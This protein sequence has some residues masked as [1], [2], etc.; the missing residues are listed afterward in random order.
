MT[1]TDSPIRLRLRLKKIARV[2]YYRKRYQAISSNDQVQARHTKKQLWVLLVAIHLEKDEKEK[3]TYTEMAK[4]LMAKYMITVVET[5]HE[6]LKVQKTRHRLISSFCPSECRMY[7]RFQKDDLTYLH[8][9]LRFPDWIHMKNRSWQCGEEV[10]LLGL[11]ELVTGMQQE[12]L[13]NLIFG[14]VGSGRSTYSITE[15]HYVREGSGWKL[16]KK[17]V[18]YCRKNTEK[19]REHKRIRL[20]SLNHIQHTQHTTASST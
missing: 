19:R 14:G 12:M 3:A 7:F 9:L 10:F 13:A 8:H 1:L 17:Y 5:P 2:L 20:S 18:L 6:P 15:K 4:Y 11:A 16:Q